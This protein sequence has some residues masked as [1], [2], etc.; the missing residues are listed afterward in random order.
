MLCKSRYQKYFCDNYIEIVKDRLLEL[1]TE[2]D[3]KDNQ[4]LD[5]Y[6]AFMFAKKFR[7]QHIPVIRLENVILVVDK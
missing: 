7:I 1:I 6:N 3:D 5:G 2:C 4:L